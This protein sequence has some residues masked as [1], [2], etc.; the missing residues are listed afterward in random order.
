MIIG[1]CHVGNWRDHFLVATYEHM[2]LNA[3]PT[4]PFSVIGV[5]FTRPVKYLQW[6]SKKEQKMYIVIY[7]CSLTRAVFLELLP[8][9]E[10]GE[11][12]ESLKPLIAR[13]GRLT[14]IYS[15]N[16]RTFIAAANWL[17]KVHED[18]RLNTFLSTHEITWQ[19]NLSHATWWGGQFVRLIGVMKGAFYKTVGQGQ[20]SWDELIE[21]LLDIK[22]VL[23]NRPLNYAEDDIQL[24]TLTPNALLFKKFNILPELQS[25]HLIEKDLRKRA[26]FL[27]RSKDA[28]WRRWSSEYQ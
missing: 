25:Y 22:I 7:S 26:K 28:I 23:N 20:L 21:V 11:F 5:D 12:I 24:P 8:G 4:N 18:E 17:K 13:R 1:L 19:F 6:K 15:D 16:G 14:K 10:T 9:L 3:T 27:Q 2:S